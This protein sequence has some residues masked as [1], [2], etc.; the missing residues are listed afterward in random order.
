MRER[1][2]TT[3]LVLVMLLGG[4]SLKAA[5]PPGYP[6]ASVCGECHEE[7]YDSWSRTIH[8]LAVLDPIFVEAM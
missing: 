4:P 6:S 5:P 1:A 3:V 8:A 7:T 2:G